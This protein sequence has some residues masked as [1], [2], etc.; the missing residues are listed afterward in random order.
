MLSNDVL[1]S[2]NTQVAQ[3]FKASNQYLRISILFFNKNL[4]GFATYYKAKSE[5]EREHAL[6]LID[7][8]SLRLNLP[9]IGTQ[10]V[11]PVLFST[12]SESLQYAYNLELETT[13]YINNA[14]K[15]AINAGDFATQDFLQWYVDEQTKEEFEANDNLIKIRMVESDNTGLLLL[16]K[17]FGAK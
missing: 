9:E 8:I 2:L 16:D 6:K 3:E 7:Y 4:Y 10:F 12:L 17:E 15:V 13:A 11:E 1:N 14:M 5:E